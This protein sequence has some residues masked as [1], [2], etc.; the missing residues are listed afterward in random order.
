MKA[1]IKPK[2]GPPGR[3]LQFLRWFCREDHLEEIEG[4][5]TEVFRKQYENA[6]RKANWK[7]TLSVIRYLRPE[8]LKPFRDLYLPNSFNME[9][10][11]FKTG[12]MLMPVVFITLIIMIIAALAPVK[13]NRENSAEL[14]AVVTKVK[15]GG[16]NDI[17]FSL[18][19]VK[20]MYYISHMTKEDL[21]ADNLSAKLTGREVIISYSKPGF[22]S[23]LSPMTS[24]IQITE[25]KLGDE[26]IFSEFR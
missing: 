23:N 26:V 22:F 20:G 13:V 21:N 12:K 15:H 2:A 17:V 14:R 10:I 19:G 9:N 4:D 24:T 11:K 7:F 5:L 3:A 6:P 8:F 25:L 18:D 16:L 1:E